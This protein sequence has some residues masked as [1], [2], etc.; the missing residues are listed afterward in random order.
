MQGACRARAPWDVWGARCEQ[1]GP[2]PNTF[3]NDA[4]QPR[5]ALLPISPRSR[6]R[7]SLLPLRDRLALLG[8]RA[9]PPKFG[10]TVIRIDNELWREIEHQDASHHANREPKDA[11]DCDGHFAHNSPLALPSPIDHSWHL[12]ALPILAPQL[13]RKQVPALHNIAEGVRPA[14]VVHPKRYGLNISVSKKVVA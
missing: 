9:D 5:Q 6:A 3:R 8:C 10:S 1:D 14:V 2:H 7:P 4:D 13:F 12:L 11:Q